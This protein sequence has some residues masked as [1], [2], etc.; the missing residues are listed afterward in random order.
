MVVAPENPT[1]CSSSTADHRPF[2]RETLAGRDL[3]TDA[4]DPPGRFLEP[5]EAFGV[6]DRDPAPTVAQGFGEQ[7]VIAHDREPF[8]Q[9][10]LRVLQRWAGPFQDHPGDRRR[11]LE[12]ALLEVVK[13]LGFLDTHTR[14][15]VPCEVLRGD[16]HQLVRARLTNQDGDFVPAWSAAGP[17]DE[18]VDR[19]IPL[20]APLTERV[21]Q[22]LGNT[23]N[24][25]PGVTP[26]RVAPIVNVVAEG[27]DSRARTFRYTS[28]R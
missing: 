12:R 17:F 20:D 24:L 23:Q 25:E 16:C 28:V 15:L 8:E 14:H 3:V 11:G 2:P 22:L 4:Q 7:F 18:G 9:V 13:S 5:Q 26:S 10:R 6:F 19:P 1:R 27:L 21:Q